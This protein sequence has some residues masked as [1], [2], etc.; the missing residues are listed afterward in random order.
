MC[1]KVTDQLRDIRLIHLLTIK[2][3]HFLI[4]SVQTI[5]LQLLIRTKKSLGIIE[6]LMLF[7]EVVEETSDQ[8]DATSHEINQREVNR[9]RTTHLPSQIWSENA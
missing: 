8:K 7:W 5:I 9:I 6:F 2:I 3:A 4:K 1:E